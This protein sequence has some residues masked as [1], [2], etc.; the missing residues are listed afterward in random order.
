MTKAKLRKIPPMPYEFWT[1]ILAY[2]M[3][4]WF[5]IYEAKHQNA[6]KV[7]IYNFYIIKI[8]NNN[9]VSL[10]LLLSVTIMLLLS[11]LSNYCS[12][13]YFK[14]IYKLILYII[15]FCITMIRNIVKDF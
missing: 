7:S 9:D 2:K 6:V 13:Y 14:Y 3:K 11:I 5:K 1:N 10:I 4:S 8:Y 15:A 12:M